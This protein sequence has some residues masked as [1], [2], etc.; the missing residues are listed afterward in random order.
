MQAKIKKCLTS[1]PHSCQFS[2][3][4]QLQCFPEFLLNI[5]SLVLSTFLKQY[6]M[7]P[8]HQILTKWNI[9]GGEEISATNW[10]LRN[11]DHSYIILGVIIHELRHYGKDLPQDLLDSID[12]T[13]YLSKKLWKLSSTF[14]HD[15]NN[16]GN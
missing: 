8:K 15:I 3:V 6:C 9:V 2:R 11:I 5:M 4:S 16:M 13:T 1:L 14:I 7:L 12:P 10:N